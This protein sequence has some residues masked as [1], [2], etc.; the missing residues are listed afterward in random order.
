MSTTRD[1]A[2]RS[3][4]VPTEP[5]DPTFAADEGQ[6]LERTLA[7]GLL[8]WTLSNPRK[9][10]ALSP[11]MLAW[12]GRRADE[13]RGEVVVLDGAGE[14]SFC[15]GFD[16]DALPA[17][18][19]LRDMPRAPA[20]AV[21]EDMSCAPS[22]AVPEDMSC[23]PP[24]AVP[25]DMSCAPSQA[26]PEDMSESAAPDAP[27]FAATAALRRA[28]ATFIAVLH[29]PVFGAGV[30]LACSCDLRLA[31]DDTRFTIPAARLGVV[32]HPAGVD[33]LQRV[34]GL[35][36]TQRLLL[37]GD[38]VGADDLLRAGGVHGV[39]PGDELAGAVRELA[40]RLLAG[41]PASLRAH[42]DRLRA[43]IAGATPDPAAH[44]AARRDAYHS[45]DY[46]EG[47][48]AARERRPP[49][50]TGR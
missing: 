49:R 25:E 33:L 10:N 21:P 30:E 43:L 3:G 24:Q 6:V 15:A 11:A 9:R 44:E 23:S 48:A 26:V 18:P 20:Q 36:V 22:Q 32:Y 27:L 42:R 5:A 50:F 41:A 14:P 12:L 31:R 16:L 38:T 40:G 46:R 2:D 47:R 39:H 37:L 29:G 7:P 34:L 19:A 8:R 35:V 13:L 1:P 45:E 28:D 17:G 4:A